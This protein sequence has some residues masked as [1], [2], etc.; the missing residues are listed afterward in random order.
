MWFYRQTPHTKELIGY[1]RHL[2]LVFS[3][4]PIPIL[5]PIYLVD[6]GA[7]VVVYELEEMDSDHLL[8]F[9]F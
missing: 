3:P 8:S 5:I 7:N 1:S 6:A 9:F 4:I 2:Q